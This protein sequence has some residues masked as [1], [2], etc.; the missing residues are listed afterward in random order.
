MT[1]DNNLLKMSMEIPTGMN[2][3]QC[4]TNH[5]IQINGCPICNTWL[6]NDCFARHE[7]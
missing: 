2:C 3:K 4:G 5:N 1:L 6:C 7:H